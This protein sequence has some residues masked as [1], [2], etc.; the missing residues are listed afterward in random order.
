MDALAGQGLPAAFF[1]SE[2]EILP[3]AETAREM[4]ARGFATGILLTDGEAPLLQARRTADLYAQ[5]L[6]TR[7]RLVCAA[8]LELTEAQK[9]A[10]EADGFLLWEADA[11]PSAENVT[12]ARWNRNVARLLEKAETVL[13]LQLPT[14]ALVA[15]ALPG[16]AATLTAQNYTLRPLND[17]TKPF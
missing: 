6:H 5:I 13:V 1:L 10:L 11:V 9:L 4:F 3:G 2:E 12:A 17:W 16:L 7:I 15:D 14:A 8:G